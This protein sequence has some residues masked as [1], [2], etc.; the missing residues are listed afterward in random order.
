MSSTFLPITKKEALERGWDQLDFVYIIGDAYVD[1]PSFGAAII[2]RLIESLGFSIGIISQPV[3]DRDYQ[4]FGKPKYAFLVT[5]GNIDSMVAHYTA[6]KRKRSDDAYTPGGKAGRRPDRATI[7]YSRKLRELYPDS[8]IVIGG[9]EASLRRFAHYDYWDDAVRPSILI[10]SQADLL[11][12][13]MGEKVIKQLT[14]QLQQGKDIHSIRDIRDIRGT[15]YLC[16][17][18]EIPAESVSC[19]S[20]RKVS[21]NKESYAKA[22]QIQN[23]WQ[24]AVYGKIIVQKQTDTE[25][26]VQNPPMP[27]LTREEL[28]EVF[29]LPFTRTYHPSYEKLG[30]VDAIEEVEFSIMQNRGC[31]GNCN[32]C[33]ITFH[34]GRQV[35]SRSEESIIEEAEEMTRNP[36]FK[37][38]IHDV[39]GPTANF[40]YP[41]CKKQLEHGLCQNRKCLAPK[42]CPAM[43]IDHS[44]YVDLLRKLRKIKG[45]KKVFVRS[46]IRYDYAIADPDPT[47]MQEL[48]KYHIS[49]QLKVAPEHCVNHV[50]DKMGKPHVQDF[51]RFCKRFYEETKKIGKEQY[52]VP[53]LM[54]SHPGCTI[55]DAVELA[56]YLKKHHM[57]P[58]QVQDFYPTPGT[59]S[60]CMFYTGLDPQT[61][62]PVYVPKTAEEKF[63]QRT[64]LQYYKPENRHNVIEALIRAHRE[65]LIGNGPNCLVTPDI[66]YIRTHKQQPAPNKKQD[67]R[68]AG[69]P[70]GK[71]TRGR[72]TSHK[73]PVVDRGGVLTNDTRSSRSRKYR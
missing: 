34:Q 45:V 26:L 47:F 38:Y 37:G 65:D 73:T 23:E 52:L 41:S 62:E 18:D 20:F 31:F 64:L 63:Y 48:V 42:P 60:T 28:D 44:E 2:S 21:E 30:G 11:L 71:N 7:V 15:C 67:S 58:E 51:D 5:G 12:Y 35:V 25:Y 46:G 6:A 10:D 57:R 3:S 13:G 59:N 55:A 54:S 14:E 29:K 36:R 39:G 17:Q 69:K 43:D 33:A 22:H 70:A 16:T 32:F 66:E 27:T 72:N 40:R 24:D 4:E 53:Y 1:H 68:R 56:V 8:S 49:G 19:A 50:L 61:M 9:L